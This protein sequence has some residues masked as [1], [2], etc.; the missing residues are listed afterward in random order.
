MAGGA[1]PILDEA[2]QLAGRGSLVESLPAVQ[3]ARGWRG[4]PLLLRERRGLEPAAPP[5]HAWMARLSRRISR[6]DRTTH[7]ALETRR[8]GGGCVHRDHPVASRVRLLGLAG[9]Y[10]LLEYNGA[11]VAQARHGSDRSRALRFARR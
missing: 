9:R 6:R 11:A 3:G 7:P 5:A 4:Y 1:A 8:T 10:E 2:V